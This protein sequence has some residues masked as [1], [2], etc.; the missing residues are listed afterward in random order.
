M[1]ITDP[2]DIRYELEKAK[3]L[4]VNGRPGPVWIDVPQDIQGAQVAWE[5][6]KKFDPPLAA[7]SAPLADELQETLDSSKSANS[8]CWKRHTRTSGQREE[9]VAFV[10]RNQIPCVF[11]YLSI[12]LLDRD[13]PLNIGRLGTKGDR[14][15]NFAVQNG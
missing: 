14:A 15:G 7:E 13:N 5:S 12:D 3:F 4:A 6:L 9:F 8:N 1:M 10:E 11:S 2:K